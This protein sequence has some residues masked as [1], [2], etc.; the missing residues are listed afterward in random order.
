MAETYKFG[1][2]DMKIRLWTAD[3]TWSGTTYDLNAAREFTLTVNTVEA[4]LPGDDTIVATHLTETS[5]NIQADFG[6]GGAVAFDV[7]KTLTGGTEASSSNGR[8]LRHSGAS[9]AN[10]V[11][12]FAQAFNI[13]NS[14]DGVLFVP[15]AKLTGNFA[16]PM[17]N[18]QFLVNNLT[19]KGVQDSTYGLWEFYERTEVTAFT[20][21]PTFT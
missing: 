11:G 4:E 14:G 8:R 17:R 16:F 15:K 5:V 6:Y 2:R 21:P 9:T 7:I 13:D 12:I 18:G 3:G 10:Y 20:I 1:V 19:L